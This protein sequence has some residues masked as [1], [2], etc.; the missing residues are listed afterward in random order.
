MEKKVSLKKQEKNPIKRKVKQL[1]L[2]IIVA[3]VLVIAAISALKSENNRM[4]QRILGMQTKVKADQETIYK[5]EQILQERPDYKD[6]WVQLAIIYYKIGNKQKAL[7]ALSTARKIDPNNET[8][9][10]IE[11]LWNN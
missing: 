7:E 11:D 10:L 4:N 5:W 6:G 2:N 1:P 9:L 8:L 3:L